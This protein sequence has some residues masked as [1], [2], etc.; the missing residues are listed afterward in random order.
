MSQPL[1]KIVQ[2]PPQH[3]AYVCSI[4]QTPEE[5]SWKKLSDWAK[6]LGLFD[7]RA[8]HTTYGYNNPPPQNPENPQ[9]ETYGY[10]VCLTIDDITN[11]PLSI[12][13]KTLNGGL[14]AVTRVKGVWNI[15]Q[16]WLALDQWANK[17]PKYAF[18]EDNE[19]GLE[20]NLTPFILPDEMVFDLYFPIKT[21]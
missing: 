6:P 9:D 8:A 19:P 15:Y 4:S 7:N 18:D 12:P 21:R 11:P 3:V 13:T 20:E 2:L 10:E 14:Y 1:I 5:D 16:G 17:H